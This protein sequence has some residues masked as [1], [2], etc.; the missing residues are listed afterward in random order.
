MRTS[1]RENCAFSILLPGPMMLLRPALPKKPT[2]G[3]TNAAGLK[4]CGKDRPPGDASTP[5]TASAR[6]VPLTP[7]AASRAAP[8][9]RGVNGVPDCHVK[10]ADPRQP[11]SVAPQNPPSWNHG[12]FGPNG[13]SN[14][15]LVLS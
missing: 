1:R 7:L 8:T 2:A 14:E 5:G 10:S 9:T 4:N 13:S 15:R 11:P 12:L 6:S 3:T